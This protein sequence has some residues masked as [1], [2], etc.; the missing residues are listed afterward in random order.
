MRSANWPSQSDMR[1]SNMTQAYRPRARRPVDRP[2]SPTRGNAPPPGRLA[3]EVSPSSRAAV[4]LRSERGPIL[5]ALMVST[6][7]IAIDSTILATAVPSIVARPRRLR[8]VPVAVLGLPAGAGGVGAGLR[9]ARRHRRPQADHPV[10]DRPVPRSARV[11]C[12]FA[13]SMPALIAFRAVQG[14]GAG[15]VQPMA[16]TIAG[17]IYTVA[18]RA[19][20]QGYIAS[21]WAISSVVGPTLGGR[22]LAA[23]PRG[24]GSSSS[25]CPLCLLAGVAASCATSTR[26]SSAASTASTTLGAALL[27]AGMTPAHPRRA[28]GRPGLGVELGRRAS[29]CSPCGAV[30]LVAFV[31]VERRAAEPVLPLWVFSPAPARDDDLIALGVGAILIGLTSY[32]PTYLEGAL[33]VAPLVA[34]LALAALTLGWP[35]A[36]ALSG[37]LFYLRHRLP[38]DRPHRAW[39]SSSRAPRRSRCSRTGP[40]WRVVAV[41]CFVVGLGTGPRRH[42]DPDRRPGQ[43]RRGTSAASSTGTNM[44]ARSIGSAVGAAVFGAVANGVIAASGRP[45]TDPVAA[46]DIRNR[47]VPRRCWWPPR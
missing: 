15:A 11:L 18:E 31:L 43:R 14:L 5:I 33:G 46:T 3:P 2:P 41:S 38:P 16:I 19:K 42:P 37:R 24:A 39:G 8:P 7:L 30:L 9:E 17:D 47:G 6:G 45:E 25:T 23:A 29:A 27:T 32:V 21:V 40:R 20:A 4:G 22:L 1:A 44:F 28:R 13:W 10:R 36:A 34:G 12:G 35:L 26:T